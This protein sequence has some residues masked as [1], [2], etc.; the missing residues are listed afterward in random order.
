VPFAYAAFAFTLGVAL[1]LILRRTVPAMAAALGGYVAVVVSMSL[2]VRAFLAPIR[3]ATPPLDVETLE[4]VSIIEGAD[5]TEM[6][7]F[8][9][10]PLPD[11]W[12]LSN[13]TV[14]A[15][16]EPFIGPVDPSQCG[17]AASPGT[18]Q[19]WLG[20]LGLRQDIRYHPAEQFWSLQ[21]AEAGVFVALALLLAGFCVWWVRKR[22]A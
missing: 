4:G 15:S 6:R 20:T 17:R 16:G 2:W 19:H 12:V 5:G 13:E 7:V 18:C 10:N 22:L 11:A 8:G 3:R 21:W 14:T 9:A 1:G